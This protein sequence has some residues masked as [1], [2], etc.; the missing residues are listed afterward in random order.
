MKALVTGGAGFIG[1]HLCEVL[2]SQGAQVHVLDN[3]S[4]GRKENLDGIMGEPA[5]SFTE[6][7]VAGAG[8]TAVVLRDVDVEDVI[9]RRL[10]GR[11]D[12]L[13]LDVG[14]KGIPHDPEVRT[15]HVPG[16]GAGI[17]ARVDEVGLETVERLEGELD[18]RLFGRRRRLPHHVDPPLPLIRCTGPADELSDRGGEGPRHDLRAQDLRGVDGLLHVVEGGRT[19]RGQEGNNRTSRERS[20]EKSIAPSVRLRYGY[21]SPPARPR[22]GCKRPG[23]FRKYYTGTWENFYFSTP[24]RGFAKSTAGQLPDF[25]IIRAQTGTWHALC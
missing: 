23:W 22:K 25:N 14:V 13:L 4:T 20:I 2:L 18:V 6:G 12:V 7:D 24:G 5:F 3:L 19:N 15:A 16:K 21:F 11:S 1:S 17:R 8:R 9:G 10:H